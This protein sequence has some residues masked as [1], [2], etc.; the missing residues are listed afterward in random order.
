M[1]VV[2]RYFKTFN[3]YMTYSLHLTSYVC[4]TTNTETESR[5]KP[6]LK[7]RLKTMLK[8]AI[9]SLVAVMVADWHGKH[10]THYRYD[11]NFLYPTSY[12]YN[13]INTKTETKW[14]SDFRL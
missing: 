9:V 12:V 14:K 1:W 2:E 3:N 4:D 5:E 13:P 10:F 8:D 11:T 6:K 7:F